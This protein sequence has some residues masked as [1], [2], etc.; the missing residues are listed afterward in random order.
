MFEV[1]SIH[2]VREEHEQA[3]EWFTKG[4]EAGLPQAQFNLGV[5]LDE[6]KEHTTAAGWY[7]RAADAGIGSAAKNLSHMYIA[8]RGRA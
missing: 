7:R 5:I 8:G 4:A 2:H 6:G 3:R 1:G